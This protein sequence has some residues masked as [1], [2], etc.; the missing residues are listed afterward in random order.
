V[1]SLPLRTFL[2][3]G[4]WAGL[5]V[6]ATASASGSSLHNK[7][8]S[9]PYQKSLEFVRLRA[10]SASY[11]IIVLA[12][13]KLHDLFCTNNCKIVLILKMSF[14]FKTNSLGAI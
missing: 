9:E 5:K 6:V 14:I 13:K 4:S 2:S 3:L 7:L 10:L 1:T 12:L 11:S 8:N